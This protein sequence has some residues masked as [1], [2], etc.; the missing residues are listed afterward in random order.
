MARIKLTMPEGITKKY[1]IPVRITDLNYG[2]HLGN[3]SLITMIHEARMKWLTSGGFSE[4]SI[5]GTGLIMNEL[6]ANYLNEAFYGDELIFEIIPGDIGS[7]GFEIYYRVYAERRSEKVPIAI[8]KTGMVCFD[9]QNT[10]TTP[11]PESFMLFMK[12]HR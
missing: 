4:K 6:V 7:I 3:D 11:I 5:D 9:D 8:V 12:P 1:I 2:N 10:N